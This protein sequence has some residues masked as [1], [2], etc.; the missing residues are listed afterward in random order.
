[1]T[2]PSNREHATK[3]ADFLQVKAGVEARRA[4][5]RSRDARGS[6]YCSEDRS[7]EGRSMCC[8]SAELDWDQISVVPGRTT[9]LSTPASST[10]YVLVERRRD[11]TTVPDSSARKVFEELDGALSPS[12]S[13][14][15]T[16]GFSSCS[17][18]ELL[19]VASRLFTNTSPCMTRLRWPLER[20]PARL[21]PE[22]PALKQRFWLAAFNILTAV[23]ASSFSIHPR[24]HLISAPHF[25]VRS[26][27]GLRQ[28]NLT[29]LEQQ[30]DT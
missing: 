29:A 21:R 14:D 28:L 27:L 26:E 6:W 11:S 4:R 18:S 15:A 7:E 23:T 30:L 16:S 1:M 13:E 17:K 3:A 2:G 20:S 9:D 19:S 25:F 5:T 10:R 22:L 12:L 24:L 8:H